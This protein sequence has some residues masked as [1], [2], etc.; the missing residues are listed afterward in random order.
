LDLS[1]NYLE[2]VIPPELEQLRNLMFLG[3]ANNQITGAIPES[4]GN[5]STLVKID[6]VVKKA[7]RISTDVI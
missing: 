6:L 2:G 5:I 1:E 7:D 3:L 4:I